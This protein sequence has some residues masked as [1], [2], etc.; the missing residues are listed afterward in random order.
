MIGKAIKFIRED[1]WNYMWSLPKCKKGGYCNQEVDVYYINE[2]KSG[3]KSTI[4]NGYK[5]YCSKCGNN[6]SEFGKL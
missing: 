6:T 5:Y 2:I 4:V 3:D 1:F